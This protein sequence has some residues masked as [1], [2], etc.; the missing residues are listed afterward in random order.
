MKI[1]KKCIMLSVLSTITIASLTA[2]NKDTTIGESQIVL[3]SD[4]TSISQDGTSSEN[5]SISDVLSN[6]DFKSYISSIYTDESYINQMYNYYAGLESGNTSDLDGD[7]V[8][9]EIEFKL[10]LDPK[11][12]DTDGD[13]V[14]DLTELLLGLDPLQNDVKLD[15]DSDGL[16]N[17]EE[18]K[19]G[20]NLNNPDSDGDGLTD[21]DEIFVHKTDPLLIDT[22]S[23]GI[24]DADEIKIGL[25]P[26]VLMSDGV[27][28]DNERVFYQTISQD[29]TS[30]ASSFDY[31]LSAVVNAGGLADNCITIQ[32][33]SGF[34]SLKNSYTS[35]KGEVIDVKYNSNV[36]FSDVSLTFALDNSLMLDAPIDN[37]IYTQGVQAY[38]EWAR[39]YT[40]VYL[41]STLTG[42]KRY[43]VFK[44]D[45]E[46]ST[47]LPMN[48]T[49]DEQANTI[50]VRSENP[51][52]TY[53]LIDLYDWLHN[54]CNMFENTPQSTT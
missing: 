33:S 30:S 8:C 1:S 19:Y 54:Y 39:A 37:D 49:Y 12:T 18:I 53:C 32:K 44:Y 34:G 51:E 3:N 48:C 23:D 35:I 20:T 41:T 27:T 9:D 24:S 4:E 21:Y 38:Q 47:L 26:L 16:S 11:L 42:V 15:L 52:G 31:T 5:Q 10:G 17:I 25:N 22:D 28:K 50:T 13:G 45:T 6:M 14:D 29:I 36:A 46:R 43:V 2:C 7:G 40:D